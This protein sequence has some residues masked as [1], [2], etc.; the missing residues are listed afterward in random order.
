MGTVLRSCAK[1]ITITIVIINPKIGNE[2]GVW[3]TSCPEEM[4][5]RIWGFRKRVSWEL[6]LDHAGRQLSS[7]PLGH[8]VEF[9]I[10]AAAVK[11]FGSLP[12]EILNITRCAAR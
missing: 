3:M 6:T 1:D 9:S 8:R 11:F 10:V 4:V 12:T 2:A 7:L 5:P